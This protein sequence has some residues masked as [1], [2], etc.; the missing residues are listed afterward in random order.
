MSITEDSTHSLRPSQSS[1]EKFVAVSLA[2]VKKRYGDDG[3]MLA[4]N[5]MKVLYGK[6]TMFYSFGDVDCGTSVCRLVAGLTRPDKG[7]VKMFGLDEDTPVR[8]AFVVTVS[9]ICS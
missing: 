7:K 3:R 9:G 1:T 4:I 8:V 5:E 2:R 6:I